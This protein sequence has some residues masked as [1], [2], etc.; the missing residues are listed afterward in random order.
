VTAGTVSEPV[1]V[2]SSGW[3]E[4]FTKDVNA[5]A[6]MPYIEGS[7]PLIIPTIVLYEVNKKILQIGTKAEADRF[8]SQALRR[9]VI[10]LDEFLSLAASS[11]SITHKLAM[12]DAIIYATARAFEAEL[13]T[14]DKAFG[15][16]PG[17][18][19]L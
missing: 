7:R 11:V 5:P 6:F 18:I 15:G 12:A 2:D 9:Q 19:L 14:S 4:Y 1:L 17:V 3:L 13:V 16:L 8:V 10:P